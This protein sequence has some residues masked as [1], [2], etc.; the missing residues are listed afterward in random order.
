M[1]LG[2]AFLHMDASDALMDHF[3]TRFEKALKFE[4]KPMDVQVVFSMEKHECIVDINILEGRRKF[5]AHA[6]SGDFHRSVDMAVN[7]L[8]RQMSKDRRR[9]KEHKNPQASHIGKLARLNDALE[10]DFSR[11]PLRKAS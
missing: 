9:L 7:K 8:I 6:V 10:I 3:E 1:K 2:Y 11:T 4:L 5:K